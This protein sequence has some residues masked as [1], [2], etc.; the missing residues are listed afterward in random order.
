MLIGAER[1]DAAQPM[2]LCRSARRTIKGGDEEPQIT[3]EVLLRSLRPF[4][5]AGGT[6]GDKIRS[7]FQDSWSS[8]TS[9]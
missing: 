9:Q 5:K 2:L 6:G 8:S 3:R 1:H 4:S 7:V